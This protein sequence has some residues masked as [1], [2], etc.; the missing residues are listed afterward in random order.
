MLRHVVET[1]TT[2]V[3]TK[4]AGKDSVSS[5]ERNPTRITYCGLASMEF[6]DTPAEESI[7][8]D[9]WCAECRA[10]V[11]LMLTRRELER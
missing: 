2:V 1:G 8:N 5:I 9:R 4:T 10:A 11:E 6:F 3:T 7:K